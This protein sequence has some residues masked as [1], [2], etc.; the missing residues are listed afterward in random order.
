MFTRG[1]GAGGI[2][3]AL[4]SRN[5]TD[6]LSTVDTETAV[7]FDCTAVRGSGVVPMAWRLLSYREGP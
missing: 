5:A 3:G 4:V 6:A 2:T 7:L 1:T